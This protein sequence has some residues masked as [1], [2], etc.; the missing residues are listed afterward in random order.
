MTQLLV[1]RA[2]SAQTKA[3]PWR[4]ITRLGRD[5]RSEDRE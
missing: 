2:G 3:V 1:F 4:M 5:V